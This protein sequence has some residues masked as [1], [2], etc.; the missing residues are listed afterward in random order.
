M[1]R[2]LTTLNNV[3]RIDETAS[4][5]VLASGVTGTWVTYDANGFGQPSAGD[6]G[7]PLFTESN[8]DGSVGDFTPDVGATGM[9]TAIYGNIRA[10]TDQYAG[11][12]ALKDKL[13][14]DANGKLVVSTATDG[15]E[16]V[17]ARVSKAAFTY[18]HLGADHTVIEI[19]LV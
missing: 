4:A 18:N 3:T 6:W 8:R 7:M 15:T 2:P 19:Y 12:P 14:L 5:W 1:F 10:L 9:V 11:T 17:V 13:T 16:A